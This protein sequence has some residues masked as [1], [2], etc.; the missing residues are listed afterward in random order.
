MHTTNK[1]QRFASHILRKTRGSSHRWEQKCTLW[2]KLDFSVMGNAQ[3]NQYMMT[4]SNGNI[5]RVTGPLCGD[6][7]IHRSPVNSPNKGHA[8][9]RSFGGFFDLRLDKRLSKQSWPRG[10]ETPSR[11]LLRHCNEWGNILGDLII[12][13][14]SGG[15][16]VT[17]LTKGQ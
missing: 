10:F 3:W 8:V 13:M 11:S 7:W 6:R 14:R 4:S 16:A 1:H 5:F 12:V 2:F 9:T 17:P 15:R